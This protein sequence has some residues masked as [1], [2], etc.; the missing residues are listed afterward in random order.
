MT[1][2][3]E[4]LIGAGALGL[5][6]GRPGAAAAET[7]RSEGGLYRQ[8]WFL[9][10][11]L[12]LGPDLDEAAAEGKRLAVMWELRGCPFCR[13]THLIN[14][15]DPAVSSYVRERFA[16]LQL[17][18]VGALEVTDFDGEK[19]TEKALAAKYGVRFTPTIQFFPASTDGLADLEPRRR[20]VFRMIGYQEPETFRRMFAYVHEEA[21]RDVRV[22]DW[23]KI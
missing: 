19:L 13:D 2:R 4:L 12:E 3:R 15:A 22:E 1:T 21:Y 23:L 20:E 17:D 8:S 14:F 16:I 10:S 9:D 11:F 7:I 6:V 5:S 18:I